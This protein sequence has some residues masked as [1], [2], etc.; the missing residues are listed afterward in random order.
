MSWMFTNAGF[1]GS[2]RLKT[3]IFR[4]QLTKLEAIAIAFVQRL[5][6]EVV[7]TRILC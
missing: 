4:M 2:G 3:L 1:Q 6:D 5:P 7:L